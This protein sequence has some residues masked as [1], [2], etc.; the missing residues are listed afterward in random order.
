MSAPTVTPSSGNTDF[1]EGNN[2]S[3]PRYLLD[4]GIKITDADSSTFAS[5]TISITS[6][7]QSGADRLYPVL[8]SNVGNITSS[9]SAGTGVLTLTSAGA[10]ATLA[11]W[12]AALQQISFGNTSQT[13]TAGDRSISFV[14]NDGSSNSVA[15]TKTVAVTAVNDA[16]SLGIGRLTTDFGGNDVARAITV[17]PDGK[18]LV[19]G[20]SRI[21][22]GGVAT[23]SFA[24]ARYNSDGSL[25]TSFGVQGQRVT[26]FV[27]GAQGNA[28][29][30]TVIDAAGK[31]TVVGYIVND[32]TLSVPDTRW[33]IARYNADGSLD[34][35]FDSD[36]KQTF[37]LRNYSN[38]NHAAT[39]ADGKILVT[40]DQGNN[41]VW[42]G[43]TALLRLNANG[44]VDTSF[45]TN[46]LVSAS[47]GTDSAGMRVLVLTDAKILL[48]SAISST[49]NGVEGGL[50]LV[51][52]NSNGTLDTSFDGDGM[53]QLGFGSAVSA[54]VIDAKQQT[55]GKTVVLVNAQ[56]SITLANDVYMLRYNANGSLDTSFD[57]DGKVAVNGITP[58]QVMLQPDGDILVAGNS[59]G[60]VAVTRFNSDGSVDNTF[61]VTGRLTTDFGTANDAAY[62]LALDADGKVLI[63]G[64]SN[65][66][67]A[68]ARYN[69]DGSIDAGFSGH[70]QW[71]LGG[72]VLLDGHA[73]IAD[74]ELALTG[75][76]G[77]SLTLE[78]AGAA[79][80]NDVFVAKAGGTLGALTEG[81]NLTVDGTV[82]GTVAT[83]H[84]GILHLDFSSSLA[85]SVISG[86]SQTLVN[87]ALQQLA[88][89]NTVDPVGTTAHID[90]RFN[91][92]NSGAQ[93]PGGA[94]TT[95]A[96]LAVSVPADSGAFVIGTAA[97]DVLSGLAGHNT[98]LQGLGGNDFLTGSDGNDVLLGGAGEDYL[99][100][101]SGNDTLDG[102]VVLDRINIT[103]GNFAIYKS[104]TSAVLVDLSGIT[105]DGG[106]GSG[107]ASGDAS[108]G[109][110]K[111]ININFIQGSDFNDSITGSTALIFEMFEGG[112]GNDTLNGGAI[113]DTLNQT[114]SNRVSYQN[115]TGAG[116]TVDFAASTAV[117]AAGS[118]AGSDALLNFN[119]VRGSN[120]D[121]TLL[122]SDRT[123]VTEVF[124]GRAGN[125]SIDGRGGFDVLAFNFSTAT[126]GVTASLVSGTAT[127]VGTGTDTFTHIEGLFGTVFGDVLT[128]GNAA[129]GA[130]LGDGLT[131]IFRGDAGNDTIDGGQGY[132]RVDYTNA[133]TGAV[134]VLN[135]TVDGSASDGLG[136][137]DVLRN[138]EGVRGS[139]FNDSLTGSNTAPFESFEGREGNDTINGLG[140]VDRADYQ[141]SKSGVSVNLNSGVVSDGYGGTDT[142]LNIENVRGSRD[143]NDNIGG[144]NAANK[145]EGLGGNDSL[146]GGD[147]NDVLDGGDGNDQLR[148]DA[149]NDTVL[150]GAG[151]D[152]ITGGSGNDSLVGGDGID[153]SDYFYSDTN[154]GI[155]V[156][157]ATG[158]ATGGGGNDILSGI[159]NVN[160]SNF[161]DTITGD[162]NANNLQG[163][164]GDDVLI[165][166]AGN[167]NLY[168]G[169]GNDSLVGGDGNDNLFGGNGNDT[170]VGGA[171]GDYLQG[172]IG[173]DS[174]DGGVVL[175]RVNYSDGN[176]LSYNDFSQAVTI[177]LRGITGDGSVGS[178]TVS[179]SYL[180]GSDVSTVANVEFITGGSGN[181]Y[182]LGSTA[183]TFEQI[184]GGAGNDTL[185]GGAITQYL[186]GATTNRV[187]YQ[188]VTGAGVTVDFAAGAAIGAAGSNA[189]SDTL[190]NFNQVRGSNFNDTLLGSDRTDVTE[191]FD[192]RG[193]ND[194]IDG[195]GGVD[196]VRYDTATGAVIAN[197][198]TGIVTG[199]SSGTD[200][201]VNIEGLT[202]TSFD[203]VLIG[204]NAANGVAMSDGLI[205]IFKG[206]AG[207]DTIDGGQ[208]YDRVDYNSAPAGVVVVLNDTFDGSASDGQGG[209]DVL[210]NIEAVR[211]TAFND[212]LTG[213]NTAAF[214]SF[215]GLEGDDT[216]DG[217]GGIDRVDYQY[218]GTGITVNLASGVA[219]DGH[220]GTDTLRNIEFVRGS[221]DFNDSI[222]GSD[223]AN[224][225]E[226]LGGNDTLVGGA[227][228]DT[229]D[230]GD[231]KDVAFYSGVASNFTITPDST[232]STTFTVK[233]KTTGEIDTLKDVELV[234]FS[235]GDVLIDSTAPAASS[236]SVNGST[237]TLPYGETLDNTSGPVAGNFSVQVN[238]QTVVVSS[239][240]V[241][242]SKV[243]LT[244]ATAAKAGDVVTVSY[245]DP[246]SG[247][248]AN[249]VQDAAGND[250]VSLAGQSVTNSTPSAPAASTPPVLTLAST[251]RVID[252][253]LNNTGRRIAMDGAA[254]A[255]VVNPSTA[256][257]ANEVSIADSDS[258]NFNGG[259][260]K[261][262]VTAPAGG[263]VST[264]ALGVSSR[265]GVF[266]LNSATGEL[267]YYADATYYGSDV[268]NGSGQVLHRVGEAASTGT[269]G[270]VIGQI[271]ALHNGQGGKDLLIT[272]NVKATPE[273]TQQLASSIYMVALDGTGKYTQDWTGAAGDKTVH[274]ELTDSAAG[275]VVKAERTVSVVSQ[276]ETG[277]PNM[278]LTRPVRNIDEDA[279]NN[280][281]LVAF[282]GE[283][284]LNVVQAGGPNQ[285]TI[286]DSDSAN[287]NGGMLSIAVTSGGMA[288]LRLG[289][290]T[291]SGV[292]K[293]NYTT[294]EISYSSDAT[295]YGKDYTESNGV[296]H[297][298]FESAQAG[299][300]WVVVGTIDSAH[301]GKFG[302][303][304][305]LHLN[306]KATVAVTQLLA[307]AV[308]LMVTDASGNAT[309]NW[310]A[311]AGEKL[312]EF[313]LTD[314]AS[315]TPVTVS[316]AMTIVSH[317]EDDI[318]GTPANDVFVF[319][320]GVTGSYDAGAG[321]DSVTGSTGNDALIGGLGN[322]TLSGSG[323]NDFLVG[324]PG[325]DLL[326]G[327]DGNDTAQYLDS[328]FA[329]WNIVGQP[330]GSFELTNLSSGEKDTL[331]N[332]ETL[333]FKDVFKTL[334]TPNF[335][336]TPDAKGMN[337]VNG[338]EF[339]DMVDAGSLATAAASATPPSSVLTHRDWISTGSGNDNIKAGQGGDDIDAG[340][341]ND[342]I[343]G[344]EASFPI[345]LAALQANPNAGTWELENHARYSGPGNRYEV[346]PLLDANGSVT[347]TA[348]STYYT[349]KDLRPGS[350]DG[351]DT[352][353]NIDALQFSDTQ[354]RLTPNM[355]LNR[356]WDPAT[357]QPNNTILGLALDGTPMPDAMGGDS[358]TFAGSDR[359]TGNQGNDTLY[360]GAGADTLRGDTGNDRLDGGANRAADSTA[361]WEPNGSNGVDVA[362]FSGKTVRYTIAKLTDDSGAVTGVPA[363]VYYTVSD[364]KT[365]GGDGVDTLTN[366]EVLRFSDGEKNLEVVISPNLNWT[367]DAATNTNKSVV[368]GLNWRGTDWADTINAVAK[369]T[370]SGKPSNDN[371]W[372]G[373]GN[374]T[375][376]T[377][378]GGDNITPGQ[379]NDTVDGGADGTG[380]NRWS[381]Y[382]HVQY[383]AA[384]SRFTITKI[385]ANEFTVADKLSAEFGG[386][387]TD[388]LTN[389]EVLDF[390]DG[391]KE[392]AVNFDAQG[393]WNQVRGTDF[394][395]TIEADA[396]L[397][398]LTPTGALTIK[399]SEPGNLVINPAGLSRAPGDTFFALLGQMSVAADGSSTFVPLKDYSTVNPPLAKIQLTTQADGTLAG[400]YDFPNL[401]GY[402]I[403]IRLF[404]GFSGGLPVGES[405]ASL[406]AALVGARDNI[407]AGTG[408]DVVYGGAGGD[409]INDSAGND[410]YDGGADGISKNAWDNPDRVNFSGAQKRYLVEVLKYSDLLDG[411]PLKAEIDAKYVSG[412]VPNIIRVTDKVPD[413]DGV[414]Y[415]INV[416]M[417]QFSDAT[418]NLGVTVNPTN[419]ANNGMNGYNGGILGD[420][421]DATGHDA[422]NAGN[423]ISGFI[424]HRDWIDGSL[425]NDTLMGGAGG[426][427]LQGGKGNDVIDGGGNGSSD[428]IWNNLDRAAYSNSINRYK[429]EFFS[430][431]ASGTGTY[432]DTGLAAGAK[433]YVA[434]SYYSAD[435]L[436][437]V[438]DLYSD[439][440]GGD[441]RDVLRNIEQLQFNDTNE[442]LA[443]QYN[444]STVTRKIWGVT[445][446]ATGLIGGD[447]GVWTTDVWDWVD[448]Q[449]NSRS[450]WGTRFGDLLVGKAD[451]QNNLSG[452]AGNDSIV[453][454][455]LRDDLNG[456]TGND[457][458]DG[459][460]NPAVDPKYPWD[461]GNRYDVA[462]FDAPRI[463]F[464]IQKLNDSSGLVT[465][466]VGGTYYT[467]T[468]LIPAALGGLGTDTVFNVE[469]LQFS[470][471]DVPL[472]VQGNQDGGNASSNASYIGTDFAD[473]ITG[474][475]ANNNFNGGA[476]N[477]TI[478]AGSGNDYISGGGGDDSIDGGAG[479][480]TVAYNDSHLRYTLTVN[481]GVVT[482]SDALASIY[483]GDGTDTL[484]NVETVRFRDGY[485]AGGSFNPDNS[486]ITDQTVTGTAS[487][488]NLR[489]GYGND[490]ILALDGDDYIQADAGNDSI[491]GGSD[492]SSSSSSTFWS[493][494]DVVNY[495]DAQRS[496]FDIV[497]LGVTNGTHSYRVVDLA[498]IGTISFDANG[499]LTDASLATAS[500]SIG[501]GIDTITKVEQLQ[502]SGT[503]LALAPREYQNKLSDN[504]TDGGKSYIG[505]FAADV[506]TSTT[507]Y[508]D[509]FQGNGGNDTIDGGVETAPP[510]ANQW[511]YTDNVRYDG[512]RARYEV[513][514]VMVRKDSN[515]AYAIV[516]PALAA[517]TDTFAMQVKDLLPDSAGGNGID[518]LLNIEQLQ[519]SDTSVNVKPS[520]NYHNG[521]L[522]ANGTDFADAISGTVYN[523]WISG[524]AGDDT[525]VGGVGGDDFEGGA[526]SDTLIGGANAVADAN[527]YVRTDTARYNAL[528]ERFEI[529]SI[530]YQGQAALQ[531]RDLLPAQYSGSLG[532]DIL[533]GVE[534]L[535]FNDRWIDVG[536]RRWSWD[537]GQGHTNASAEGTIFNDVIRGDRDIAGNVILN[538][539]GQVVSDQSDQI[540][541]NAGN[542]VLIGGGG[543]DNLQGGE[544]NDVI[545]GGANGTTGNTWQDQDQAQFSGN[546]SRYLVQ[547][548]SIGTDG[549]GVSHIAVGNFT[550][551]SFRADTAQSL[552][553]D[554]SV[555]TATATVLQ[556]A[557]ANLALASGYSSAY[558]VTDSLSADLGG[559]GT[560]LV[561]NVETLW[562]ANGPLEVEIRVNSD[563]WN[564]DGK[565]D[566]VSVRGTANAD[567]VDMAKL[568]TLSDKTEAQLIAT[569]VD[570]D[571]RDGNDVYVGGSGGDS[572]RTGLGND[573]V[574]GGANS[575]TDQWGNTVRDE[576]HFDGSFSRYNLIDVTL[577]KSSGNWTLSST[578][579][580]LTG[581]S[582]TLALSNLP[583]A[584][585]TLVVA[586]LNYAI[587][588]MIDHAGS[589]TSVVGWLVAD[590]LPAAFQGSG[591]DALVNVEAL[592][593]GDKWMP[594]DMQVYYQRS[595]PAAD[596]AIVS[597]HVDGTQGADTIGTPNATYDYAGNDNLRG[598]EGNDS[599][600]GGAGGDWISGGA[601]NDN[602][603]GGG[604]GVDAVGNARIDVAQY[605]GEFARY[606]I[607]AN[608]NGTAT[609][610]DSQSDGDGTDTLVNV[611]A[612]SFSDRYVRLGVETWVNKDATT[613]KVN[614]VQINGSMLD[615]TIDVS[616]DAYTGVRHVLR[617]N[618]GNDTLIGGAGPD[619]FDGGA[620]EDSIVGGANGTD[621]WGNPGFDVVRYQGAYARYTI[622]D[623]TD[624][625]LTWVAGNT[626]GASALVRVTD[627]FSAADGGAGVD[628]LSG[629]EA[630]AFF[631]R[632]VM[633]Q[634]TKTVLDLN[635]DGRPDNSD[636]TGTDN[637]DALLGG[638]TNDHIKGGGGAD[639]ISGG[640]GGDIL[641]GGAGNDT[642]DGGVSGTDQQGKP[643]I[644]VAEYAGAAGAYTVTRSVVNDVTTFTVIDIRSGSPDGTDTLNNIEGLQF[645][646]RF[647][648]LV[649]TSSALDLNKDGAVDLIDIRGLDLASAGDT[650]APA[651][652]NTAIAHRIA[653]G[654]GADTLTGGTAND[655]FVG[656]AGNDSITGGGGTDRAVFS[657]NSVDY[658]WSGSGTVTVTDNRTGHPDGT[659]TLINIAELAFNDKVV[660]LGAAASVITTNEVD[661]DGN[662]KVD[663]A[664]ITGTDG[665]DTIN[666][667]SSSLVN[668]I[669]SGAGADSLT[670]GS[671]AD[672]FTPGAG[673]DTVDGG[674]N[675]GLDGAG[676]PN[677]DRVVFS[678]AKADYTIHTLQSASFSVTG[679]V[680]VGDVVSVTVG[681]STV[682]YTAS[683]TDIAA[684][685]TGLTGL[686][687]ALSPALSVNA[688][689]S[690]T[691]IVVTT[692]D[693][694]S[695][696]SAAATNGTH[697]VSGTFAV[698]GANQS[699]TSFSISATDGVTL[700]A[701]MNL[702]YVVDMNSDGDTLDAG[703]ISDLFAIT[704]ATKT[705]VA[706]APDNWALTLGSPL[707]VSPATGASV[708]LTAANTDI[709]LGAGTVGYDR[710]VTVS[711]GGETDTLRGVEQL[712]FSDGVTDLSFKT[713]QKASFDV[714]AG[715][716]MVNQVQGTD[717]ADIL[718]SGSTN[719]IFTGGAGADHFVFADDSGVDEIR[720]FVAGAAGDRITLVLGVG[721]SDGLN[722]S[723]IS[724]ATLALGKASQQGSDVLIDLGA[725]NSVKLIG[726]LVENLVAANF[727][728]TNTF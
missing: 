275:Q 12:E 320:Q 489:G 278:M 28:I 670:G 96:S 419:D 17:L 345:R 662:Q 473:T 470:D 271:D 25:D 491:D 635:G 483:G 588:T 63:A 666:R 668:F 622:E 235:D 174:I 279:N 153:T 60:N 490:T 18:I 34:T 329:D 605:S 447:A 152:Y 488:D 351:T 251:V 98:V 442:T 623:S 119:Y 92:G 151:N 51:R 340:P 525:L 430:K 429:I 188:S 581:A 715:L 502:F 94:L 438:T 555:A 370:A 43:D 399:V 494:G 462:H 259:H 368:V 667:S 557:Y 396:L 35:S 359:L 323:G 306:D 104:A 358:L 350:P 466:T 277:V 509:Y 362:E 592:S 651:S 347:G 89:T 407:T 261:V 212:A 439:A 714:V 144:S 37:D 191:Q 532:T 183:L 699:G 480:D 120:F 280:G 109:V 455:N 154:A 696:V 257:G 627:S 412:T 503:G 544:G 403:E 242:G 297:K 207:N 422:A 558:L 231:G 81:G 194:F 501:Y 178:G 332:I 690:G 157:L 454:S 565:L 538:I 291:V 510:G 59:Q 38:L 310:A 726:V 29:F 253:D 248:D 375:I 169:D 249:A 238:G 686:I 717:L 72:S 222:T 561:F 590:R 568:V 352:V 409:N 73:T 39:Q 182:I 595:T 582:T 469:R 641:N 150:G 130:T 171:G 287:F 405:L 353:F 583:T 160:G 644:D 608:N 687:N 229:L 411:S 434:A 46:G 303:S 710:W 293:T 616:A 426:D 115:T 112:A 62:T 513:T 184:E 336:A 596:S 262:W 465:G 506:L 47:F 428:N 553:I 196:I 458:I 331:R 325:N 314:G 512:G 534:S 496:R 603:D 453:G 100:G 263:A 431:V 711:S 682:S 671:G 664:Y 574:D 233:D 415:L 719:E 614:D 571:L 70:E 283:A 456:G 416:E 499:H 391:A 620:G 198:A 406:S 464:D 728:A 640:A 424:T 546:S 5:A 288:Q 632:F 181:D 420:L 594:L 333:Q 168:G 195:R 55:D 32:T 615:D 83:N 64:V 601:G 23:D 395:D 365:T 526:G 379:G 78:R 402:Q 330:D 724:S 556:N 659:D 479:G 210:R 71:A 192:G 316:R 688:T 701:G 269:S 564:K 364:S 382:D 26:E 385:G 317:A 232:L 618:E 162:A 611:E 520:L 147:G 545:D 459:G 44:S 606:T 36:G 624:D 507:A 630:L 93:G 445:G 170:L 163:Q 84:G 165:G 722:G 180:L 8:G 591:V 723:G 11:Q 511:E 577:A 124:D 535:S 609:V 267:T 360:G 56:N 159:E 486:N 607:T 122:G 105:G 482:V 272:L 108:V 140:G 148:G 675:E 201:L 604:N 299:T 476:G 372:T 282:N 472:L 387:G 158:T 413:G 101:G 156:N 175:D 642:L 433:N 539:S 580:G 193:G 42:Y 166:G 514:G 252:E 378:A 367:W 541:G 102:G 725:G 1:V 239:L 467:V 273:V 672:T 478:I 560:D 436:I 551:A 468:H 563:D 380:S 418:V 549:N 21:N 139:A 309:Q 721:D 107:S 679:V 305:V 383:D 394:N 357:G 258:A 381:N 647:V 172:G 9:W 343:D 204:G 648:S 600:L 576:V 129:S 552:N 49:G 495:G 656:G 327:G 243:V 79:N 720:D 136:G 205:E 86:A 654:D 517:V 221:R 621:M 657:G 240:S 111:L 10:T 155:V 617:G 126:G 76:G 437:V 127:G 587:T 695:A 398:A 660:K 203:D 173:N 286:A 598:N 187:S 97:N 99:Q 625:G 68:L 389:V 444:D 321:D 516:D 423:V 414:N 14:L 401:N 653:G 74:P 246:T 22:S 427:H 3:S 515:G 133:A 366:I 20:A 61:G 161:N 128:G 179:S 103:D 326:G 237:L 337:S 705:A 266:S 312:I 716:I 400:A 619:E 519:F 441:G 40:G 292:F 626:G 135:D 631:D 573:Y 304:L 211:G 471:G 585:S 676:N 578:A 13:P 7:F 344:G 680:E 241:S 658:G 693:A 566:W 356:G 388:T 373:A 216:I 449:V 575:G 75:F 189:G 457:T 224:S 236:A 586:D 219:S 234:R 497:D 225:L 186:Y 390:T 88:Y 268:S 123:D 636:I 540:R 260:L 319:P 346:T 417:I 313:Q 500:T 335:W 15:V 727:E 704:A 718:R 24:E 537:N 369:E 190:A 281:R 118:N 145:L 245:T 461:T 410:F 649:L 484:R 311:A 612:L 707:G 85:G 117:G 393:S 386:L 674:A 31:A 663:I 289:I 45:G 685:R 463:Q 82:I 348:G 106:T 691:S 315:A 531:V 324:G 522:N 451:S 689:I 487:N 2:T 708:S 69:S 213:S 66:N 542:D 485:W 709:T 53:V 650:I 474:N 33:A 505:T 339:G 528:F 6:G 374:D 114:N 363:T 678:G 681:S 77:A 121:D 294:G 562:F 223:A 530:T 698:N 589:Q 569:R 628:I 132:D 361:T 227:G 30:S 547:A 41:A 633:L 254:A 550:V 579:L 302:D 661:T 639:S 634:T 559:D 80:A 256:T 113:T 712:V 285:I 384:Q 397:A 692:T 677:M 702:R 536:I 91:D 446:Q 567:A 54:R 349:V 697:A 376:S 95:V 52:L 652:G 475:D 142:L 250:V 425:G 134:V 215:E 432:D 226:G 4:P 354:V 518:L 584:L 342:T 295:Y 610:S 149:G 543:G 255:N 19:S 338:T 67:F 214:E 167:D 110:D 593:F 141:Y 244:L 460:A 548:V 209:T 533:V 87:S 116:V 308:Y 645:S 301:Q 355:W 377:G 206:G 264:L 492:N 202:G 655:V 217:L 498:S 673:N 125:D 637:A 334:R 493:A 328:K 307:S 450:A 602:I 684:L 599:I 524:G 296:A 597:A 440:M 322:D 137:T 703:D 218:S 404:S 131:E 700:A 629:I 143:F 247:N 197:L 220:G 421:V 527:G 274:Y 90:W 185:D 298:A 408:N 318:G 58:Q 638:V 523:D 508:G 706:D 504:T 48:V 228:N 554:G 57:T 65:G 200:T 50:G 284:G 529:S 146:T 570:V 392:L 694:L 177:D 435:G 481:G 521:A 371:V 646:D 208:G 176:S 452:N 270:V 643:L 572:V 443:V 290:S 683:G 448:T 613:G 164:A 300:N 665:N 27:N 669:D 230:G 276:A 341:G 713:G 16:T 138:I 265:S 199:A 477:D